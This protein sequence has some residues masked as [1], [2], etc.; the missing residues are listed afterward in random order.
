[1]AS[2]RSAWCW[3]I[4]MGECRVHKIARIVHIH[5]GRVK[6]PPHAPW[7]GSPL[8]PPGSGP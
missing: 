7:S 8:A 1:M 5:A 2:R 3:S 4:N 6:R